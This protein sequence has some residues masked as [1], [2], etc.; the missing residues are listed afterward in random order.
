MLTPPD[1]C[2]SALAPIIK[3]IIPHGIRLVEVN[4]TLP[5]KIP[6]G[7]KVIYFPQPRVTL[8]NLIIQRPQ[9]LRIEENFWQLSPNKILDNSSY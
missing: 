6:L 3:T 1:N 5:D 4:I 2:M 9:R 7:L 8:G